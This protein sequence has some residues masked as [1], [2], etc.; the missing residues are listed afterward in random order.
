MLLYNNNTISMATQSTI[1]D[2]KYVSYIEPAN[3]DDAGYWICLNCNKDFSNKADALYHALRCTIT[4]HNKEEDEN[5]NVDEMNKQKYEGTDFT[6]LPQKFVATVTG[7]KNKDSKGNDCVILA[8]ELED[9]TD[10][11]QKFSPM[12]YGD[13]A[14]SLKAMGVKDTKELIGK[15]YRFE[16]KKFKNGFPRWLPVAKA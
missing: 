16:Q 4:L 12:H 15:K 2:F 14:E 7:E 6:E 5:M 8:L 9:G 11:S 3:E 1:T 10:I 13:L